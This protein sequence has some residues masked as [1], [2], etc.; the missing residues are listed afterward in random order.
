[1]E[2]R[3]RVTWDVWGNGCFYYF[4]FFIFQLNWRER[5]KT[6]LENSKWKMKAMLAWW[7]SFKQHSCGLAHSG[8]AGV[9]AEGWGMAFRWQ[10]KH[11]C[12]YGDTGSHSTGKWASFWCLGGTEKRIQLSVSRFSGCVEMAALI[13]ATSPGFPGVPGRK[14]SSWQKENLAEL[15]M[16]FSSGHRVFT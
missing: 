3:T 1:M 4:F 16:V 10:L 11:Q 15:D 8:G 5:S 6:S 14:R 13:M 9:V 12:H 7:L 2:Q